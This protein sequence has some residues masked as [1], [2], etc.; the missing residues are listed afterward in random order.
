MKHFYQLDYDSNGD[1]AAT[2]TSDETLL[3]WLMERDSFVLRKP[4]KS[5]GREVSI[6]I[7]PILNNK[8]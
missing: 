4:P 6:T 2:G 8:L 5:T 3:S 1:T 7:S